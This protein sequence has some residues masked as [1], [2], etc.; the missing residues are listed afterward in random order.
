MKEL[1]L[2]SLLSNGYRTNQLSAINAIIRHI[3]RPISVRCRELEA[4]AANDAYL[5]M[6]R[7]TVDMFMTAPVIS[8]YHEDDIRNGHAHKWIRGVYSVMRSER[9]Y[10]D[11]RMWNG[12]DVFRARSRH[13]LAGRWLVTAFD[14]ITCP[15]AE[16]PSLRLVYP[17]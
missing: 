12:R 7:R 2:I 11:M 14:R 5:D 3:D 16:L 9:D 17:R 8:S 13:M 15:V 1:E 10:L 4:A 6:M